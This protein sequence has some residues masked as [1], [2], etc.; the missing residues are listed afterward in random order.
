MKTEEICIYCMSGV[1]KNGVC[2]HCHKPDSDEGRPAHALP[3]RHI[4][5]R[6]Y[7]IGRVLGS[8]GYGITYLAWDQRNRRRVAVKEFFPQH[9]VTRDFPGTRIWMRQNQ[10]EEFEHTKMRFQQEAQALNEL[11][12]VQEIADIWHLFEEN[13]SAYY[14]MEFL[15]GTDL[16]GYL[17][18]NGIMQWSALQSMMRMVLRALKAVHDKQMIHR[19][20]SPDN[21]FI[22]KDGRAKLIDFGN[23]RSYVSS[24]PLTQILKT[25]FAPIEQFRKEGKQGPWTDI[26]SLCVTMYYALSG[27]LP[28]P[29]T[30][31]IIALKSQGEDNIRQL[32]E[33]NPKIPEH[34]PAAVHKGMEVM[35]EQRYQSVQE[36]AKDLF[37]GENI[38]GEQRIPEEIS[39]AAG[40]QPAPIPQPMPIPQRPQTI[41]SML[42]TLQCVQGRMNGR[43]LVLKLGKIETL[44]RAANASVV[45]PPN[46]KGISRHQCSFMLDNKGIVYVRDDGSSYGTNLNGRRLSPLRWYSLKKGDRVNFAGEEY[47]II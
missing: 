18:A 37:S 31:R 20:I 43:K 33:L 44:G 39:T 40:I 13:N 27:V 17:A 12:A 38:F 16:K 9:L 26:Y 14:V 29:A 21:I 46:C 3:A 10:Q 32:F 23:A 45:Y 15:E 11:R 6:Q 25:R 42:P 47:M 2:T 1:L 7:Y 30:E 5:C 19:D 36:L 28:P 35:P 34:V 41:K 22:L 4:L 8:G 24:N